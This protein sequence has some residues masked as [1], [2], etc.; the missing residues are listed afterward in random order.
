LESPGVQLSVIVPTRNEQ[1]HLSST[2]GS[3]VHQTL[4]RECYEVIVVDGDS[5]DRTVEIVETVQR[6]FGNV[7]LFKNPKRIMPSGM[8]IGLAHSCG[9]VIVV[10]GAH[11]TYPSDYLENCLACLEKT[12]ADVVGGPM[13]TR[14]KKP[15]FV[16]RICAAL[17][18]NPFGVGNSHFRTSLKEGFVDTV[19]YGAYR[20]EILDRSGHFN[21]N[22]VRGQDRELHVRIRRAG[23]RIYQSV[24]LRTFYHPA[25][26]LNALLKKAFQ[27][28]FWNV[29]TVRE[30]PNAMTVKHF[31]PGAFVLAL[32][33]LLGLS[34]FF[35]KFAVLFAGIALVYSVAAW[36]FSGHSQR[37][38][39]MSVRLMMP[40]FAFLFHVSYGL[41]TI[42]G[43]CSQFVRTQ[44]D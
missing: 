12:G 2:L 7:R 13:I 40:V 31:V 11:T 36:Y 22:L 14:P 28:G 34:W 35:P 15:G 42:A 4:P 20:R 26:T 18:S 9:S 41:G 24:A 25:G 1:A 8:N 39:D 5:T 23:G 3:L 37:Q 43:L 10:A 44:R 33:L 32:L 38:P 30:N 27:N 16:P 21:E 29:H 19:P 17:L 6:G